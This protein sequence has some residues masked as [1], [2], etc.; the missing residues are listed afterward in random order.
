MTRNDDFEEI[1]AHLHQELTKTAKERGLDLA[2]AQDAPVHVEQQGKILHV[3]WGDVEVS[4]PT[5][6]QGAI[7]SVFK[8]CGT[9]IVGALISLASIAL[10]FD[11]SKMPGRGHVGQL[12]EKA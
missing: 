5:P 12:V 1:E 9:V 11:S 3:M 6:S 8:Q 2:E 7:D 4:V 10:C